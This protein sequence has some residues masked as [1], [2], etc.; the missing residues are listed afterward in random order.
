MPKATS[1]VEFESQISLSEIR[2]Y[3]VV[4]SNC[5]IQKSRFQLSVQEQKIILYLISKIKPGDE[6]FMT[7]EF[8]IIEFCRVCGIYDES[9]KNYRDIKSAIKA[10]VDKSI[11][12]TLENGKE[13]ILRWI[14]KPFIDRNAGTMQIKLDDL[15]KPY[16]LQLRENFTQFELLYTL[17]MKS[18]YS[19][20][21]YEI[22][23][24]Y[25][26]KHIIEFNIDELKELLSATCYSRYPDFRRN[27]LEIAMKE[28]DALSDINVSY[29]A[30]KQG[31]KYVRIQFSVYIKQDLDERFG[32][33][34]R[35]QG[36]IGQ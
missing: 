36:I 26:Y 16:L 13:T 35:I 3:K 4:K 31:R 12:V 19:I 21:L 34:K 17:A 14:D 11:W 10:L 7:T 1:G 27:V 25:E 8:S 23:R 6:S 18:Q 5:L 32:T 20:R 29:E 33:W 9:G 22:L 2:N 28:I 15:L 24:S 30:I